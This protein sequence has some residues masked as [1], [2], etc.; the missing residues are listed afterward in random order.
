[1]DEEIENFDKEKFEE[2]GKVNIFHKNRDEY[3]T[4]ENIQE[5][6]GLPDKIDLYLLSASICLYKEQNGSLERELKELPSSREMAKMY[7][8]KKADLYDS[9]II[10]VKEVYEDRL[11]EL[12]KYF[13]TGFQ[14]LKEWWSEK[15]ID[16]EDELARIISL[17]K[18]VKEEGN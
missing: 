9:I 14:I 8:F 7:T 4:F 5:G 10:H 2:K 16:K 18:Y 6:L 17:K 12:E 11:E 3:Q 1:M 15:G 13:Y